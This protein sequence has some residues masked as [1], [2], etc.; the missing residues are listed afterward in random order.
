V[1]GCKLS[2]N[3]VAFEGSGVYNNGSL[4]VSDCTLSGNSASDGGGIFN[5]SSMTVS[6]STLS[7]NTT[8]GNGGG[9][10]YGKGSLTVSD[11]TL[12]GNSASDGGGIWVGDV[13]ATLANAT[14]A[15]NTASTAGGG[16]WVG[17]LSNVVLH[18]TLVATNLSGGQPSDVSG[19][20][21][22]SS[23]YNLIGDGSGGLSTANHNLLGTS[24][25]PL[26]PLL[27]PLANYGGPT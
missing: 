24:A 14:I 6:D 4:T 2:G 23:N 3:V 21:N 1:S 8:T 19:S 10:C 7:G 5:Y 25:K 17:T 27:P 9:I 18:N 12:F 20:L 11:C 15:D 22:S 16:I 26:N 13:N